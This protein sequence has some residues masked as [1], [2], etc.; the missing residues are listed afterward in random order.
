MLLHSNSV[1]RFRRDQPFAVACP[2]CP[3]PHQARQLR[4]QCNFHFTNLSQPG[5]KRLSKL[6]GVRRGQ[7]QLER[8]RF[9]DVRDGPVYVHMHDLA[10]VEFSNDC[11]LSVSLSISPL[12]H[13]HVLTAP[14]THLPRQRMRWL[15]SSY[16]SHAHAALEA[17]L[18]RTFR[19]SVVFLFKVRFRQLHGLLRVHAKVKNTLPHDKC[20]NISIYDSLSTHIAHA[21]SLR[22][23]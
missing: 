16:K 1:G 17:C 18:T 7:V 10:P 22:P 19:P 13:S 23:Q 8:F 9:S 11:H 5:C 2:R 4:A 21:P 15:I 14:S 3:G 6:W 12:L 20:I